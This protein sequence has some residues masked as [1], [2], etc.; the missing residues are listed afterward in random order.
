MVALFITF[1]YIEW[2]VEISEFFSLY[3]MLFIYL[4]KMLDHVVHSHTQLYFF[5][6]NNYSKLLPAA[7]YPLHNGVKWSP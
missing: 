5:L 4:T 7:P 3:F 1:K 6:H 2:K